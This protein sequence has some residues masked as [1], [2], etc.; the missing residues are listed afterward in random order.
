M[1]SDIIDESE[2]SYSG[3]NMVNPIQQEV[4]N[5]EL[6]NLRPSRSNDRKS[7]IPE[8][9]APELQEKW[10]KNFFKY[11]EMSVS[12]RN[13]P[14][15]FHIELST[16]EWEVLNRIV[17]RKVLEL[18]ENGGVSLWDINIMHYATA[19]TVI[20]CKGKLREKSN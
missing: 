7:L 1:T 3:R 14:T 5:E 10:N 19:I 12:D 9:L 18:Q 2:E 20:S 15:K 16:G 11:S 17:D 4:F 13:F 8:G 6:N